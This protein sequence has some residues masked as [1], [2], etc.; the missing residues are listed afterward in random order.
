LPCRLLPGLTFQIAQNEDGTVLVGQAA[1]RF[2]QQGL[3][4]APGVWFPSGW[5]GH[6]CRLPFPPLP[7]GA[8]RPGLERRPVG[9]PVEPVGDH[10]TG[11]DGSRLTHKDKKR[12]LKSVLRVVI[13]PQDPAAHA[14]NHRAMP[15]HEGRQ[16]RLMTVV[17]EVVQQLPI[18]QTR[19]L[20]EK[21]RP[22]KVLD[23]PAYS[24]GRHL[25]F[26]ANSTPW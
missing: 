25:D 11:P 3:E 9:H 13:A 4:I 5:F 19:S 22:A 23:D 6:G 2:I 17:D 15:P 18:G 20:L 12:G 1:Q 26:L 24:A 8:G 10:S 21:D 7:S 14:P 16:S